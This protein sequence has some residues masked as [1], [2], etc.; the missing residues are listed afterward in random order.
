[1][2]YILLIIITLS[3]TSLM[4]ITTASSLPFSSSYLQRATGV[5]ANYWNPANLYKLPANN[6]LMFLPFTL[7]VENN[8]ISLNL[9]NNV[10]GQFL[11]DKKK[12]DIL[13]SIDG[14]MNV[15]MNINLITFGYA[16][17]SWSLSSATNFI[18][19]G[20]IDEN[21]LELLL[22]GNEYNRNYIFTK[23][24]NSF[25]A[26]GYQD[27]TFSYGN[28]LI[29]NWIPP[30]KKL[31][32]P[33][34][35]MG[36]GVSALVGLFNVE[37]YEFDGVFTASDDGLSLDQR[38]K[39][40]MG[41]VG[42]GYKMSWGLSSDILNYDENHYLSAGIALN[43]IL[44]TIEWTSK[45]EIR[46]Y[47]ARIDSVYMNQL[48]Q[49]IFADDEIVTKV[50]SYTT[51]LPLNFKL[52]ANY[53]LNDLS[54]SLDFAKYSEGNPAYN[55]DT[56]ISFG[57]EYEI[58]GVI[59]IQLGYRL[60]NGDLPELYSFGMGLKFRYFECGFGYQS[61]GAFFLSENTKGIAFSGQ[62]KFRF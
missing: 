10:T 20:K 7:R 60:A 35:Y 4:C 11:D 32:M 36:M 47:I 9:Y 28:M 49:D 27:L 46:E 13:D 18:A 33:D 6:E 54:L 52:G 17:R 2:K 8:A 48:D 5:E 58:L 16:N 57:T 40:R 25:A 3:I 1:M 44:G 43:N 29:N 59:P 23:D 15:G 38:A 42:T 56:K 50:D 19:N 62:M 26:L 39:V 31:D 61:I 24:N 41:A 51:E 34:I 22:M 14:S 53:R 37:M 45:T 30:M 21:Y 55:S 12:K